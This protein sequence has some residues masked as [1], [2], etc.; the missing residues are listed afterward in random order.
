[1]NGV[2]GSG[3]STIATTI[4]KEFRSS[5]LGAYLLFERG[6]SEPS[7][8]FRTIACRLAATNISLASHIFTSCSNKDIAS[9][10]DQENFEILLKNVLLSADDVAGPILIILDGLDECGSSM[11]RCTLMRWLEHDFSELPLKFR[12]LI[13][14][15]P[16]DDIMQAL[17]SKSH[18]RDVKLDH[19]SDNSRR[20]VQAYLHFAMREVVKGK[21]P[22]GWDWE[23]VLNIL[24][25]AANGLFIWA[26]T[27]VKFISAQTY[28]FSKL[29]E[30]VSNPNSH[31]PDGLYATVFRSSVN[32][33]EKV[34]SGVSM[35]SHF[36]KIFALILF[37]KEQFANVDI[38]RI[39]GLDL[40]EESDALLSK[41]QS[42]IAYETGKPI[43]LHHTSF[44]DYLT[45][46]GSRN[47]KWFVDIDCQKQIITGRC[48]DA[49]VSLL[50][51]NICDL[52]TSFMRNDAVPGLGDRIKQNIPQHLI[53]ACRFWAQ[54]L[55]DVPFSDELLKQ[56][57]IFAHEHLLSWFEVLSLTNNFY[58]QA[59]QALQ[60][61]FEWIGVR[62]LFS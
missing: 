6:K 17:S 35:S 61:A 20:D 36:S 51:F 62:I 9:L 12:F 55:Y 41:F 28:K 43:R 52:G 39:L 58:Y 59:G 48:F 11:D 13:T 37:G 49:M 15:R 14:S 60:D 30:L 40:D 45:S 19:N 22:E 57:T 26:S 34:T 56:L 2:A 7:S 31:T 23:K 54:H 38:D 3:K 50:R 4:A 32:W 42:V 24:S 46:S 25:D 29:K 53:Y 47:E 44:Y 21:E 5:S 18:I 16:E 1:M 27:V 10:S 33:D 8:V